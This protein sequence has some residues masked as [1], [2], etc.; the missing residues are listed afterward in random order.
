[1][2]EAMSSHKRAL[3]SGHDAIDKSRDILNQRFDL[4]PMGDDPVSKSYR[5]RY[6]RTTDFC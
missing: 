2:T 1:M 5:L 4:P 6:T 3:M